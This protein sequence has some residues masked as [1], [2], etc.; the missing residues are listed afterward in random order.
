MEQVES[1]KES[2]CL[3]QSLHALNPW[4]LVPVLGRTQNAN[5]GICYYC[6]FLAPVMWGCAFSKVTTFNLQ[7][8]TQSR[9]F[10]TVYIPRS[11]T[12]RSSMAA[13]VLKIL[14]SSLRKIRCN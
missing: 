7:L 14:S 1:C 5:P 13:N 11:V 3:S 9:N 12:V 10:L 2:A 4:L 8:V 6:P